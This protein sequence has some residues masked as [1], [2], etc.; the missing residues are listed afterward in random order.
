MSR[1]GGLK[2]SAPKRRP[3]RPNRATKRRSSTDPSTTRTS[4]VGQQRPRNWILASYWSD[5]KYGTGAKSTAPPGPASSRLAAA[6]PCSTA[7]LQCSIR[8][9][10]P[11]R[12]LG[13]RAMS[14]AATTPGAAVAQGESHTTPFSRGRPDDYSHPVSG[15]TPT[16]TTTTSAST[17]EPSP[18][19]TPETRPSPSEPATA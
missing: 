10:S 8:I 4:S 15:T 3:S 14:P 9:V 17:T 6:A 13:H 16:P 7:L 1:G 2:A 11:N 5:Q 18:R 12:L 19:R